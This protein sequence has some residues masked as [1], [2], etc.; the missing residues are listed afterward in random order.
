M[1]YDDDEEDLEA[2]F[3]MG[4]EDDEPLDLPEMDLGLDEEDPD[5]DH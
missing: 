4:G 5:K 2:G 1:S 3:K